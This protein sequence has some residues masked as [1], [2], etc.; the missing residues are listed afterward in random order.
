MMIEA[1]GVSHR[2]RLRFAISGLCTRD[3][4]APSVAAARAVL[5]EVRHNKQHLRAALLDI[6]SGVHSCHALITTLAD[7]LSV[8][9]RVR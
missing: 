6:L 4:E 1:A 5:R 3:L 8:Q 7:I 9:Q 2:Q